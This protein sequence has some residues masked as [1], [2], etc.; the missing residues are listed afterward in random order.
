VTVE[1][2]AHILVV[3]DE[4]AI[5][6]LVERYLTAEGW[7]VTWAPTAAD[8]LLAAERRAPSLVVLDLGLPDLDGL[9]VARQLSSGIPVVAL[10]ARGEEP[11]RMAGFAAGVEDYVTKPFSPRELVA[12]IR[13]ILRRG[14]ARA[15]TAAPVNRGPITLSPADRR[16]TRA[17]VAVE[18]TGKEFELTWVLLAEPGRVHTRVAL[19]E[20]VWGYAAPGQTRTVDQHVAQ[21]RRK[22]G[23][24]VVETV[25]GLGYRAGPA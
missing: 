1:R 8:A 2:P 21:V 24:D 13:V 7:S 5:A 16:A 9:A 19:L 11:E 3:E 22:L 6:R 25:R 10:T 15:T 12:R 20:R 18:L 23:T 17:G 4:P 14:P